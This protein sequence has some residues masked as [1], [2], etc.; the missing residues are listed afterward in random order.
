LRQPH[1]DPLAEIRI[2]GEPRNGTV[3]AHQYPIPPEDEIDFDR[4][5]LPA[6]FLREGMDREVDVI[7]VGVDLRSLVL[8]DDV[9]ERQVVEVKIGA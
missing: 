7:F 1:I 9:F 4:L 8:V 3:V 5:D 6:V 2:V